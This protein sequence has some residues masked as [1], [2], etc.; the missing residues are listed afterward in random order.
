MKKK[1]TELQPGVLQDDK[2]SSRRYNIN[3][4]NHCITLNCCL[5]YEICVQKR[6]KNAVLF[7]KNVIEYSNCK[8]NF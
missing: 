1:N 8:L 5:Q 2:S 3:N 7:T 4:R 6:Q